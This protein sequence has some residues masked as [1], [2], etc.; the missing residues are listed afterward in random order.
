[1]P[2]LETV[3]YTG[4][5][6]TSGGRDGTSR[7]SDG[8]L[9]VRLSSPGSPG[10]GTNP[11]QLLAAAWSACFISEIKREAGKAKVSLP[12][13]VAIDAEVDVA[14]AGGTYLLRVRLNISLPG[15]GRDAARALADAA[16]QA[17]PL[18]KATRG[19][20]DVAINLL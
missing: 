14:M 18:S 8:R 11:E 20:V 16:N 1:M 4:K 2:Q 9:D 19:N 5:T 6:H 10:T 7:S 3:L 15:L 17:C 12:A 13:S